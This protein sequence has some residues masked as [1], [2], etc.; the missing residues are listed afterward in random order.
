MSLMRIL[1]IAV[2]TACAWQGV[3]AEA[4]VDPKADAI[5]TALSARLSSAQT[6]EVELRLAVKSTNGPAPVGDL[7]ATYSLAVARPNKIAMVLKQGALGAT[8]VCDGTNTITFVPQPPMYTVRAAGKHIGGVDPAAADM[9]TM[10]FITALFSDNPRAA[11]LGGV[12]EAKFV[13]R[14]KIGVEEFDR[15]EMKQE[16]LDWR[17]FTSPG[18][19]PLVRRIEV[20]I[21]HL[22][23]S[24]DFNGWKLNAP[25]ESERFRFAPPAEAKKVDV[26][27]DTEEKEGQD[28]DLVDDPLPK[29]KLKTLDDGAFDTASL[30][31]AVSLLVVWSGEAE[32]CLNAI[33]VATDAASAH[34]G[35]RMYTINIDE[36]PDR[37]RIKA[38]LNKHKLN[39]KT[40]ALDHDGEAVEKLELEGTPTTFLID[41]TGVVRKAYLGYHQDF[42]AILAKEITALQAEKKN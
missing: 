42:P 6:A 32:H 41:K 24:M 1:V 39:V 34:K 7:A 13:G 3:A 20:R 36:K 40:V 9:G 37:T 12:S 27:A 21:P 28:S 5:L 2:L 35:V 29:L 19:K 33:K 23:L 14:E 4:V 22:D 8:V 18:E 15:I 31:D 26:L 38:L 30:K 10:A 11:L 16:G 25:I 17:L